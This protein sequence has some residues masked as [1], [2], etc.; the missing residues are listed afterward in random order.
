[1]PTIP[2][3]PFSMVGNSALPI[4]ATTTI[5]AA[6]ITPAVAAATIHYASPQRLTEVL[7][8]AL[9]KA[10]NTYIV[11]YTRQACL[12]IL[13]SALPAPGNTNTNILILVLAFVAGI[14]HYTSPPHLTRV[15]VA[16]IADVEK[17]YLEALETGLL[18]PSDIDTAKMLSTLQL[19]VSRVREASLRNSLSHTGTLRE[20]F[21]GR[22][23]TLLRCIREV[24]VLETHIEN[25]NCAKT[26]PS[27]IVFVSV[28]AAIP[29][30]RLDL[31]FKAAWLKISR[32]SHA[33]RVADAVQDADL[34]PTLSKT[35]SWGSLPRLGP[36]PSRKHRA[37]LTVRRSRERLDLISE[38]AN[39]IQDADAVQDAEL[40]IFTAFGTGPV[41]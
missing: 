38:V 23:F 39:A 29:P 5:L 25:P 21:G 30:I 27:R 12:S 10:E 13:P 35:P 19:K 14:M 32:T 37:E 3:A 24:R 31:K 40:G 41:P 22:K 33:V 2:D 9:S 1:M 18:S 8:A 6:F 28:V 34:T 4:T 17:L 16:A 36:V 20:F 11:I 7:I 26:T 15:L